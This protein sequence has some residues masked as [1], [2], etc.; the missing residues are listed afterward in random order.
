LAPFN[1]LGNI[2][3]LIFGGLISAIIYCIGGLL[4]C[5]TIIGIPF[6]VQCFK[7]AGL[8]LAPF[9]REVVSSSS[10][11]GCLTTLFNIIWLLCGGLWTAII[12]VFFGILL[13]ITIIGIPFGRQHFKLV[14][15]SLMPFGKRII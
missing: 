11:G 6:G 13:Y 4:L 3:W 9:G 8:V 14:E 12:H 2:I 15:V 1:I 5:L 7:I 10:N